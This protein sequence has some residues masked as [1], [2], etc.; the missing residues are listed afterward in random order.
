[1]RFVNSVDI[2]ELHDVPRAKK[3]KFDKGVVSNHPIHPL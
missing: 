1:M 3:T 2:G